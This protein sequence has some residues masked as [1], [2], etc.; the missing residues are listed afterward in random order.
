MGH[1]RRLY[2]WL[3][4]LYLSIPAAVSQAAPEI[5]LAVE[6]VDHAACAHIASTLGWYK[7]AG[8]NV[9]AIDSYATGTALAAA[10]SKGGIDAAYICLFPAINAYANA[11]VPIKIVAGTHL[12]GYGLIVNPQK[13]GVITDLAKPGTRIGCTR[14][15][16]PPAALLHRLVDVYQLDSGLIDRVRRMPPPQLLLALHAG[17][18]DAAFM[19]EQY[20]TM[21]EI[22]GFKEL[23][24]AADLWP[25][26]QGSVLVVRNE[27]IEK[28]P[29]IVKKLV[30]LTRRG[31]DYINENPERAADIV[32]RQLQVADRDI[33]PVKLTGS[34]KKLSVTPPAV[35]RSL[36][37]KLDN[38]TR[39]NAQIVQE[40]IHFAAGIGYIKRPFPA[41]AILDTRYCH[42]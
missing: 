25:G 8:L 27:L 16:S 21:G 17:Q 14:A 26:L 6:F 9:R 39:I 19:P 13:I 31:I 38:T 33:F 30:E 29:D 11:Q 20:P 42:E 7:E 35:Y 28:H 34:L 22:A 18:L 37:H 3:I 32:A 41:D 2:L 10:L 15:G 36:T 4:C 40:M 24:N 1:S 12:Y 23:V 5:T